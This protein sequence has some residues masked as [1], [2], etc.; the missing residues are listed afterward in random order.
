MDVCTGAPN[1]EVTA[2]IELQILQ[3]PTFRIVDELELLN[4]N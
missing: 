2:L 3:A 1:D 4:Q